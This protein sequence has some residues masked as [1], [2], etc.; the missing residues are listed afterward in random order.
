LEEVAVRVGHQ[1]LIEAY[2]NNAL[3][4]VNPQGILGQHLRPCQIH[5]LSSF[6]AIIIGLGGLAV[7]VISIY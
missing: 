1:V 4:I 5:L 2:D 7:I 3:G 6:H